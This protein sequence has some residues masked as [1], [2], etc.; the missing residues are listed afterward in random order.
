MAKWADFCI[1]SVRYD[2]CREH[3]T[4]VVVRVDNGETIGSPVEW[5]RSQ[6]ISMIESAKT[7]VT[8]TQGPDSK[9]RKGE[10]VGVVVVGDMKYL[11]TDANAWKNDNLG[12]LPEF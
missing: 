4:D 11:R 1:S 8:I 10:R 9:W 3:I 7:F 12:E 5:P 6:V 2:L